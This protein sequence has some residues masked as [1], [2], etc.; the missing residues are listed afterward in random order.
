MGKKRLLYSTQ[1]F[2]TPGWTSTCNTIYNYKLDEPELYF[3][4]D[5]STQYAPPMFE[6]SS[7]DMLLNMAIDIEVVIKLIMCY[8]PS[9]SFVESP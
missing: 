1:R 2:S 9:L 3:L 5:T 6:E 8:V 4:N 7:I